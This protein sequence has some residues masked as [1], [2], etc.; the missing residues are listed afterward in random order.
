MIVQIYEIQDP[1]QAEGCLEAGVDH[2]GSVIQGGGQ[3]RQEGVWEVSRILEHTGVKH[4]IIPLFSKADDIYRAIDYYR[5]AFIHFCE[6]LA[7]GEGSALDAGPILDLQVSVR[8]KFPEI[9]I[10]RTIPVPEPGGPETA[11]VETAGKFEAVSDVILIDTWSGKPP[12]GGFIGIT[13]KTADREV[14]RKVVESVGIP[15]IQA[16]GLGPDNVY[17][18]VMEVIPAGVDSCTGTNLTDGDGN[19]VR[20]KKDFGKVKD[21]VAG[22]RRAARELE[23]L[24]R[25][26]K[27][28]LATARS[29]LDELE[30]A[31][32]AHSVKPSHFLRI[33][34]LEERAAALERRVAVVERAVGPLFVKT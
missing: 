12:V 19:R 10:I 26:E 30:K 33:E 11:S 18:T 13:G 22:A 28:G 6:E 5:P 31:L 32:P 1:R 29:E 23:E 3:W 20:F 17:D 25:Q 27:A 16:G 24:L 34:E 15:V 4:S 14:S 7:D 9:R 2:V 21:F 8:E